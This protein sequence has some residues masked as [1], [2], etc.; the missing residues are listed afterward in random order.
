MVKVRVVVRQ[1]GRLR[2]DYSAHFDL[3]EVPTIGSYISIQRPDEPEPFGE[4]MVVRKIWWRLNY[5]TPRNSISP[6]KK[7]G[8]LHEVIAV[9]DPAV[10]PYSS[11]NWRQVVEY[12]K[13]RGVTVEKFEVE[14]LTAAEVDLNR[15]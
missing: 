13:S 2:L 1:H 4:D 3:I 14:R 11:N 5:P 6:S 12:A 7:L 8:V 15:K 10:S 9:C